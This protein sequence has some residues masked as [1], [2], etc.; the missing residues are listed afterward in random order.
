MSIAFVLS[1]LLFGAGVLVWRAGLIA[2]RL[3][4][5]ANVMHWEM[6]D[7]GVARVD[8]EIHNAGSF[9]ATVLDVG[10][11]AP[12]LDLLGVEGPLPVT[13][14]PGDTALVVLVYRISQCDATPRSHWPV[15]AVARGPWGTMTVDVAP[16]ASHL[17][18]WQE[19]VVSS[20][21]DQ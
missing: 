21:C 13:L 12:G 4:W 8:V 11:S 19:Q 18:D 15:T 9:P 10:R 20:W 2:P 5:P 7:D 14:Q 1:V 17:S 6:S 3:V 16:G